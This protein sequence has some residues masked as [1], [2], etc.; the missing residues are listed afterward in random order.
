MINKWNQVLLVGILLSC[1]FLTPSIRKLAFGDGLFEENLPPASV[2]N[3]EAS[4]YTKI[5]PPILTSDSKQNRFFQLRL[6]DAKTGE[7]ITNVNY[8]ITV[9]KGDKLLMRDLFFSSQGPLKIKIEPREAPPPPAPPVTVFGSVEPFLGGWMSE[10]GEITV[11]G[12]VLLEGGLYHFEIE[13]FGIDLP[14][15]IFKPESAPKFDSYLSVGD[16][17]KENLTYNTKEY[18]TTLISYYDKIRNFKF[19]PSTLVASWKM[20]FNWNLSRINAV[21]IFVHEEFKVPKSFSE[22]SNTTVFN[23]T[24]NGQPVSGRALAIDPF[25]SDKALIIH[26]LLT[27]NDIIK[28]AGMKE[29]VGRNNNTMKFTLM[30]IGHASRQSSSDITT[31]FGAIHASLIWSPNPPKP[32]SETKLT[33]KFSD[34]QKDSSLNADVNYALSI[35]SSDGKE[36]VRKNNLVALNGTG[37]ESLTIPAPGVYQIEVDVKSLKFAGQTALDETRKGVARGFIVLP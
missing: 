3:R 15:N 2:G 1:L 29:V 14:R 9:M 20:P 12:P 13:I 18:N 22:F 4:L 17:F 31:D 19:E 7:N 23:A 26:Y 5:S 25:S 28:L 6:F 21:N 36:M 37:T 32:G 34:A 33:L 27:K 11:Q 35:R 10:T 8:F 24:V 16:V 30:P